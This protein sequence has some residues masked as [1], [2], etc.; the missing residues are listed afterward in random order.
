M[1]CTRNTGRKK[2]IRRFKFSFGIIFSLFFIINGCAKD[3]DTLGRDL[4]PSSDDIVVKTDSSTLISSYTITGKRIL[5]SANELYILGS[6]NDSIFGNTTAGILTQFH[7]KLLASADSIRTVDSLILYLS[8]T[9]KYGDSLS[10][11]TLRVFELN[12]KM[13]YDTN[14]FSDINPSEYYNSSSEL[15]NGSFTAGDSIIRLKI[16][17][18]D[19]ISK[20]E[21][22]PDS[23]FKDYDDFSEH[24]YGL[25]LSVDQVT[26]KGGFAYL[27]MSS[28]DSRLTMFYNGDTLSYGYEMGF[29]SIVAKANV[30]SHNY[31]GFPVAAY[32]DSPDAKDTLMFVEGL[33]GTSGRISFPELDDWKLKGLITINKAEL[34]LPVDTMF[35]PNLSDEDFPPK[36]LLFSLGVDENYDYLYDYRIDQAGT[37]YDGSYNE[38]KNAYVFNIGLHLQSFISGKIENSEMILVSRKSNSAADRVILKGATSLVSPVKLKVIYTELF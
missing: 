38:A 14:Y 1:F 8:P 12:Q 24:F 28:L 15:A 6:M 11:M 17:D 30:F 19:F 32:L 5:S 3:P 9:G 16:S 31:A 33:A 37:Y 27:N 22:M 34:I 2:I 13:V 4:L 10:A 36:L 29:T 7:P 35:Y 20:F 26:E 23:V 18:P 25:Y 21:T